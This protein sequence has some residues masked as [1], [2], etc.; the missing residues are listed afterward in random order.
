MRIYLDMDGVLTQCHIC[1][2][3]YYGM[4]IEEYPKGMRV[5]DILNGAGIST[6]ANNDDFW[7]DF[8][9]TFWDSLLKTDECDALIDRAVELTGS[10][11]HV[12]IATR[13]TNSPACYSG[14][15]I[16]IREN[17][18][19]WIWQQVVMIKQ[20]FLLAKPNTLLID[21]SQE[22]CKK[23]RDLGGH[24]ILVKRPW[25]GHDHM[26]IT[27]LFAQMRAVKEEIE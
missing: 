7:A 12:F 13:P 24:A 9:E 16:W 27:E 3:Q 26:S 10:T 19:E 11:T 17:L 1:A 18:P 4:R 22:N 2:L 23:F 8:D 25:N 14:K 5:K 21:D 6:L 20:K 15:A